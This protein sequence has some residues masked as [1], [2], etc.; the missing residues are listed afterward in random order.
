MNRALEKD[1]LTT[2]KEYF[3]KYLFDRRISNQFYYDPDGPYTTHHHAIYPY[4]ECVDKNKEP[5]LNYHMRHSA[6]YDCNCVNGKYFLAIYNAYQSVLAFSGSSFSIKKM[7]EMS[8]I[9]IGDPEYH[10][11]PIHRMKMKM[12]IEAIKYK[13]H[14]II[15]W[16][17]SIVNSEDYSYENLQLYID[18]DPCHITSEPECLHDKCHQCEIIK[19]RNDSNYVS[20][21]NLTNDNDVSIHGH[22]QVLHDINDSNT[23]PSL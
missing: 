13:S 2:Y 10:I 20:P 6:S 5:K 4:C 9:N 11:R 16:L 18:W 7:I 22:E 3:E 17:L 23:W 19:C 14:K 12:G 15:N 8:E 1:D 21:Y